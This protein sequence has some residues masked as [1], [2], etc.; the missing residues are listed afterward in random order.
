[1]N[2]TILTGAAAVAEGD[3]RTQNIPGFRRPPSDPKLNARLIEAANIWHDAVFEGGATGM[4]ARALLAEK[5]STSDFPILMGSVFDRELLAQY[6]ALP[7]TWQGY[8]LRSIL[9]DFKKKTLA[10]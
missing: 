10:G 9:K 2:T 6:A 8:A 5:L 1:M 7:A 3:A 4:R